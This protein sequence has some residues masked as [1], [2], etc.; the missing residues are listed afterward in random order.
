MESMSIVYELMDS[1]ALLVGEISISLNCSTVSLTLPT[2]FKSKKVE[3]DL[4]EVEGKHL[5]TEEDKGH[6]RV[7]IESSKEC[8]PQKVILGKPSMKMMRHVKPLYVRAHL[9]G[10][11]ASKVL[12]DNG[13]TINVMPLRMLRALGRS[14][15]DL[16]EIEVVMF[17]FTREV[18]KTLEILPIYITIGAKL[19]YLP[20]L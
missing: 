3:E 14:V 15:S 10:K 1:E 19:H 13:S 18:S 2:I 5:A 7:T 11:S 6:D 9:N 12:I 17:D 8:R 20:S 4:V 16:K